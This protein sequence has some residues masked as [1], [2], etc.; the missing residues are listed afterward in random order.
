[1]YVCSVSANGQN[2]IPIQTNKWI[3]ANLLSHFKC[4]LSL[5]RLSNVYEQFKFATV[6]RFPLIII[7]D[8]HT[9]MNQRAIFEINSSISR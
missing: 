4:M 7:F 1:M 9:F 5:C 3:V 2:E 6:D 8:M